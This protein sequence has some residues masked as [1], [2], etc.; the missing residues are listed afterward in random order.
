MPES[1]SG[2]AAETSLTLFGSGRELDEGELPA[3]YAYPDTDQSWVRAN[4]ITS[5]DG[6]ATAEG[7][8]GPMAGPGDRLIFF[9]LREL[10]DVIVV[11]AGTVRVEN[12]SGA[13][14][15]IAERQRRQAR[16]QSEVPQL[17]IVTKSGALDR[18][19]GVF[20]RTEVP[21]LVLTCSAAADET[22]R[23]LGDLAEVI[24]CSGRDPG[25]VDETA[26]LA[27][28]RARGLRRVLTE[29]GPMLLGAFIQR[30]L[31]DELCL[32]IAPYL[33]G[34]LARRIATG[35]GQ[36]MTKMGCTHILSDD[37]GY[38]YTRYVRA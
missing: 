36:V 4:F 24:D 38:L 16:G 7:K 32:T 28:L 1:G 37:A 14:A 29:G 33:V 12:Y 19:M 5:I 18:D 34:G 8:T 3:L 27:I 17:A 26:L 11:G 13:H 35:P 15:G 23:L 6:G 10:A 21:P 9:L 30:D 22:R 25:E 2:R 31:L 20:T